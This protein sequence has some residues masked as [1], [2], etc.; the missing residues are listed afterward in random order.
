MAPG[1]EPAM[2][3][4][5]DF[6]PEQEARLR[7]E[8]ERSGLPIEEYVARRL[9]GDSSKAPK[10]DAER[11]AAIDAAYGAL[12]GL[13]LSSEEFMR[14]KHDETER[15]EQRWHDRYGTNKRAHRI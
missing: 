8:A 15:E 13:G 1:P 4:T 12:A 6:T 14:D 2:T 10:T 11:L 9:V 3:L 7:A 5:L